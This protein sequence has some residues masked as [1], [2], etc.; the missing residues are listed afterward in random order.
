MDG[1]RTVDENRNKR[2]PLRYS[3]LLDQQL[4]VP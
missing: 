1:E 2:S 3:D 4:S